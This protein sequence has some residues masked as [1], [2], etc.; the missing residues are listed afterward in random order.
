MIAYS[1]S[2]RHQCA[3]SQ[4]YLASDQIAELW[5]QTERPQV[6]S[7]AVDEDR[8]DGDRA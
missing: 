6:R 7:Q 1:L 3:E 5:P 4:S 8:P 2:T